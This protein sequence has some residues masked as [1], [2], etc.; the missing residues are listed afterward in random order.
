MFFCSLSAGLQIDCIRVHILIC[1]SKTF[2]FDFW[3]QLLEQSRPPQNKECPSLRP[4]MENKLDMK[5]I[6]LGHFWKNLIKTQI[7]QIRAKT[8][9]L[10]SVHFLETEFKSIN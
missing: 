6:K 7:G 4:K 8:L 10:S 2:L 5:M 3:I 9:Q 1:K